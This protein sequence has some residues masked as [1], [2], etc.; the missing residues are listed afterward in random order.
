MS[1]PHSNP[2]PPDSALPFLCFPLGSGAKVG[3]PTE[4]NTSQGRA[5]GAPKADELIICV[6]VFWSVLSLSQCIFSQVKVF[7]G[8]TQLQV[9]AV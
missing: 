1:S 5:E 3:R 8:H 9:R 7:F 2:P 6:F 4:A